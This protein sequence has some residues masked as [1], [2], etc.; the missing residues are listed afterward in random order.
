VRDTYS[1]TDGNADSYAKA[2]THTEASSD[3]CA[4]PVTWKAHS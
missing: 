4:S 3:A 2:F 1:Y